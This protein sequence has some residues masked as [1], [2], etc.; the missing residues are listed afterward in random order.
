MRKYQKYEV[1]SEEYEQIKDSL[2]HN[3]TEIKEH[4]H[5]SRKRLF[6]SN[7][8]I[9]TTSVHAN[10]LLGD[11][12]NT[13]FISFLGGFNKHLYKRLLK[14]EQLFNLNIQF[15]GIS[16][17]KNAEFWRSMKTGTY[18]YNVDLSSAYWQIAH[19]LGYISTKYFNEYQNVDSYKQ[20]KRYCI[21]FLARTNLTEFTH[22]GIKTIVECDNS[23]LQ[24]VYD[25]I[26]HELY[27]CVK[28]SILNVSNW[29]EYNIDGVSIMS[30]DLDAV[31]AEFKKM[32]L[33]FKITECRK[34]SSAEYMY[35][36]KLRVFTNLKTI[37]V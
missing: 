17:A 11:L 25:N 19:K 31:C 22:K 37:E 1:S 5:G 21:S 3:Q 16:R 14:D 9:A 7:K 32:G 15:D 2:L 34:V 29:I 18:F 36:C 8:L 6:V 24:R 13:Q 33:A 23:V 20:A 4:I 12:S 10:L 35:G 26:R 28:N 30:Y 27:N